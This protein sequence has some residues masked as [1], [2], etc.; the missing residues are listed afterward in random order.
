MSV[1]DSQGVRAEA[2]IA[3]P[4]AAGGALQRAVTHRGGMTG[5][6]L[7]HIAGL[8]LLLHVQ[9]GGADSRL[10]ADRS[11]HPLGPGQR[12]QLFGFGGGAAQRPLGV[13]MFAGFDGGP[14]RLIVQWHS[15]HHGHRIDLR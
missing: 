3:L 15:H 9:Q 5:E 10:Q 8:D 4:G 6:H 14:G 13:D 1:G 2:G 7:A 11:L 12:R